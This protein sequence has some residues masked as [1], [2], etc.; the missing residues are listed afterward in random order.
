MWHCS[1][2]SFDRDARRRGG[3]LLVALALLALAAALLA[4]SAQA[5]RAMARSAQ[6]HGAS[7]TAE[8]ESRAAL[9]AFVGAWTAAYDSLKVGGAIQTQI[10]TKHVGTAGLVASVRVRLMRLSEARYVVGL[11]SA[12]GTPGGT[13]ARRRLSL[14]VERPSGSDTLATRSPP[15]PIAHWSLGDLF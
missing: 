8:S 4:G 3:A 15:A 1:V 11:E 7:I 10:A 2:R 6:S 13:I 9:A 14:V 12:V 5:G